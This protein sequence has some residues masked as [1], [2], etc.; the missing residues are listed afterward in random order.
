VEVKEGE[1]ILQA[2]VDN[3]IDLPHACGGNC[4]CTTCHVIVRQGEEN[5]SE[6]EEEEDNRLDMAAGL[7]IHS[8]LGCQARICGDVI[9]E[10]SKF[11]AH[12]ARES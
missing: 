5:L 3:H 1:T 2:S 12:Y 9:V 11:S 8:R 7:T 6:I 10:V 4:S